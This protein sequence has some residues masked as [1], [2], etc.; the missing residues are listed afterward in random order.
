MKGNSQIKIKITDDAI[1]FITDKGNIVFI[2]PK[3]KHTSLWNA[4]EEVIQKLSK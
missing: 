2:E 4:M 1:E 3:A